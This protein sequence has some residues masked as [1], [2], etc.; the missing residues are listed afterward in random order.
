MLRRKHGR[1]VGA[2]GAGNNTTIASSRWVHLGAYPV[3]STF[4]STDQSYYGRGIAFDPVQGNPSGIYPGAFISD[5]EHKTV[6]EVNETGTV[7]VGATS[8][9]IGT[10][11]VQ[12]PVNFAIN[13]PFFYAIRDNTSGDLLFVGVLMNPGAG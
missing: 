2:L 9:G 7:A 8:V 4:I 13:H 12:D 6:V 5:V 10:T 11:A 1:K 3:A